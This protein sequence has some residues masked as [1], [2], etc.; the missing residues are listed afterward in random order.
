MPRRGTNARERRNALGRPTSR[1]KSRAEAN[2]DLPASR[3]R[4]RRGGRGQDVGVSEGDR[5]LH[6]LAEPG[7]VD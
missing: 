4:L 7:P 1:D 5:A 2:P 3:L 6:P